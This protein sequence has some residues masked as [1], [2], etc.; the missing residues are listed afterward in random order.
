M[1]DA[2]ATVRG[3]TFLGSGLSTITYAAVLLVSV[4]LFVFWGGPLWA[5]KGSHGMRFAVSYLSVIPLA[6]A[7]LA[8]SRSF[9]GTR[10]GTSVG[11][12]WAIKLVLTAPLYYAL[13]PGGALTEIGAMPTAA[14]S[15]A[16]APRAP[17]TSAPKRYAAADGDVAYGTIEGRVE[18]DG[19]PVVGAVV[20][21]DAPKPGKPLADA[22]LITVELGDA[23]FSK[24][25]YLVFVGQ[26][27]AIT[28]TGK[29][30]HTA[31]LAAG[32]TLFNAPVP[33]G[34]K[35]RAP[36]LEDP[37]DFL[38]RCAVHGDERAA[39]ITIDHPYGTMTDASGAFALAD[40]PEGGATVAA[41]RLVDGKIE[42][43]TADVN[44]VASK[45]ATS[46][47]KL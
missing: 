6:A 36:L 44:V 15:A 10:L 18:K 19:K 46:N 2:P 14:V 1:Q 11:T 22:E 37:G 30:I 38:L 16:S 28:N 25:E 27:V 9:T 23:G 24:A 3:G 12:L 7:A 39:L 32:Q 34:S 26:P 21:I 33:P 31:K 43:V 17:A 4:G 13:A 42:R 5:T 41:V 29:R 35:A 40:V 20:V 47:L 45:T 8:M